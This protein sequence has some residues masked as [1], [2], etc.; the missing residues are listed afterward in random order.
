LIL[1]SKLSC[2]LLLFLVA[3]TGCQRASKAGPGQSTDSSV[4]GQKSF[5]VRGK[6]VSTDAATGEVV[7]DAEAIPGYMEAMAMPYKLAAPNTISELHPGDRITAKLVMDATRGDDASGYRHP[8][9]D[10]IVVVSQARPDYK[11]AVQYHIPA[12]GDAVP[13]FHLL[14]QSGRTIHLAQ[15]RGKVLLLTFIYTRC[16]LP[17]FCLRMSRNVADIDQALAEDPK[18]YGETHLLSVSFDPA[19]DTPKVLRSYGGA[20]TGRYAKEDFSHWDFA[21]PS[22]KDLAAVTQFFNVGVTPGD[23][24][25]NLTHSLSTILIGKDGKILAWYPD[26]DWKVTD[27]VA[28]MK[29]AAA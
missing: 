20:Y 26:N 2:L 28:Q 7:L 13:D 3:A 6:I 25:A 14:N 22:Q 5:P 10:Q 29:S 9:L 12:P 1:R 16:T 24:P 23:S 19:Y 18:L 8:R 27:L 17:D 11:P 21:A 4:V 15:F